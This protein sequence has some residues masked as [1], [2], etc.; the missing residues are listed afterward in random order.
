MDQDVDALAAMVQRARIRASRL[1]SSRVMSDSA[2][3]TVAQPANDVSSLDII[4]ETWDPLLEKLRIFAKI[5]ESVSEASL[6]AY[7]GTVIAT[8]RAS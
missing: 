3:L 1:H 7:F 5:A 2:V 8:E 6:I 4:K